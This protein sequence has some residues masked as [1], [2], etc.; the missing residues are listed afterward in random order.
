MQAIMESIFD[1]AYL[2]TAITLGVLILRNAKGR[3][4]F[5][6]FGA[7]TLLLGCGDAF[8]LVPRI[9]ALNTTGVADYAAAL[10]FGTLVT[11][12]TMTVFY[13]LMYHVWQ[14]RYNAASRKPLTAAVYALAI[15]R[16]ALCLFP[17]N[18]WTSADA[19]YIWGIYRNIPF[20]L[21]GIL[22]IA[23]FYGKRGDRHFR[24]MWAAIALSFA[25][26]APVVLF[27][28]SI[29]A[30]GMLMLPKTCAYVWMIWMGYRASK[31]SAPAR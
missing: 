19:P 6:L 9:I 12:V 28:D 3:R 2:V 13:V 5:V 15:I 29:P 7:M 26:Y 22:I 24:F 14:L 10:G 1:A 4:Q 16:I 27:A 31:E 20:A 17:Q 8:H 11:S 30:I 25:F 18:A 21:L 23:L